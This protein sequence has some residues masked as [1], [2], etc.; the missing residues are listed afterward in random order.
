MDCQTKIWSKEYS[1]TALLGVPTTDI[2]VK[3]LDVAIAGLIG[4]I[5]KERKMK[6]EIIKGMPDF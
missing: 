2:V 6:N 4:L 5:K 3:R 1:R